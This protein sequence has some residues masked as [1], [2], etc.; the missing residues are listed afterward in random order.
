M[1]EKRYTVEKYQSILG[2]LKYGVY[3]HETL[4]YVFET[5]SRTSAEIKCTVLNVF[6]KRK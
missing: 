6:E 2:E 1:K 4:N 3:D 5:D